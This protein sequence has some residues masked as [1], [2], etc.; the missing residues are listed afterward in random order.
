MMQ[1]KFI[2]RLLFVLSLL[3]LAALPIGTAQ[4]QSVPAASIGVFEPLVAAPGSVIEIPIRVENVQDLYAI[5]FELTFDP[6][7]V[8]AQDADPAAP[9]IQIGFGTF[10]DPGLLLY[11]TVDN[12][13]GVV[14]FVMTQVNPSEPKSGSGILFV[15][16]LKG[17]QAGETSLKITNLQISDR[18]GVEIPSAKMES[19]LTVREDAPITNPT[20]IP[21]INPTSMIILPTPVDTPTPGAPTA[22][23]SATVAAPSA[24]PLAAVATTAATLAVQNPTET[25]APTAGAALAGMN[26]RAAFRCLR[27]GGSYCW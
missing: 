27:T 22:Q 19:T 25:A 16:Y 1:S 3:C 8:S 13:Q 21:V 10:M 17:I 2:N 4:G 9:G 14:R 18:F 12:E 20:P 7:I 5:D 26:P 6:A 24:T 15:I 23:P 11:N